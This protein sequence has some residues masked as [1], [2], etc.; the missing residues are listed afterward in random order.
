MREFEMRDGATISGA[1][2][3]GIL[4]LVLFGTDFLSAGESRP[5]TV[6]EVEL[7]DGTNFEAALSSAPVIPSESP[8]QP[9]PDEAKDQ[10][11]LDL[12]T[13]DVAIEVPDMPVFSPT[14]TAEDSAPDFSAL[15]IPPPPTVIV[16]EPPRASI[17]EIPSPDEMLRQAPTPESPL[18]TEPVQALAAAPSPVEAPRPLAQP[19]TEPERTPTPEPDPQVAEQPEPEPEPQPAPESA[20]PAPDPTQQADQSAPIGA[21]PQEARLPVAKPAKVAAAAPGASA[22]KPEPVTPEKK[23]E[24]EPEKAEQP[25]PAPAAPSASSQFASIITPG[26]KD[27]LR[28][29][30]KQYFVYNGNRSDRSLEVTIRIQM[31]Q[32]GTI[33]GAPE[34]LRASGGDAGSQDVLFRSGRRALLRAESAGEFKKLPPNKYDGWKLIHVTFTPEEI[35]FAS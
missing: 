29:G 14:E 4:A 23:E 25:K 21:A 31:A 35:G 32:D 34:L 19:E 10:A 2:H 17:A 9:N 33:V 13:P 7:I 16:T 6:T 18:S 1:M 5:L 28:I 3:I 8:D 24:P 27:A 20:E 30:I 12:S 15:L 26:E 11:V 22:P